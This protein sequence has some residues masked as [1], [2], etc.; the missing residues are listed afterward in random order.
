MQPLMA[1]PVQA[2]LLGA[3]LLPLQGSA[4]MHAQLTAQTRLVSRR[5]K[6][7]ATRIREQLSAPTSL[8]PR[9]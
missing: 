8:K 2:I 1:S 5:N 4:K 6:V 9:L 7:H 3:T